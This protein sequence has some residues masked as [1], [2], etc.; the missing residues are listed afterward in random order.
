MIRRYQNVPLPPG[1]RWLIRHG[2]T[3]VGG[4]FLYRREAE[5]FRRAF[6]M[7]RHVSR[8]DVSVVMDMIGGP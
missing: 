8:N 6:A 7:S 1:C 2:D 3:T 5:A 4:P